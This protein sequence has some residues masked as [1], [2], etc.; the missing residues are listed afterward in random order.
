M[1][2][3]P[4]ARTLAAVGIGIGIV[5]GALGA[6]ATIASGATAPGRCPVGARPAIVQAYADVFGRS[7]GLALEQRASALDRADEPAVR[8]LLER[9]ASDPATASTTVTVVRV[10]CPRPDRARV[11]ADLVL[12][13]VVLPDVLPTGRAVRRAGAW[14]VATPTFCARM[15]LEDPSLAGR[16][17]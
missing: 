5:A 14:K 17:P 1:R 10:R 13:G 2:H 4:A 8:A 9:A 7:S 3:G 15:T 12:A 6:P 16:C 11:E